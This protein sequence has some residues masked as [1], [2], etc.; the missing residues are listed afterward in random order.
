MKEECVFCEIYESGK[1]R[2]FENEDFF[3][4]FDLFPVSPGHVEIV[5]KRHV[6]SL[7]DLTAEEWM[8]LQ[9]ALAKAVE[10]I[11]ATDLQELYTLFLKE[12]ISEKAVQYYEAALKHPGLG[13][14][15]DGY[16]IGNNEGE[17]AGRTIHH[18]HIHIIPRY[19]GD[20]PDS[21]GGIRNIIPERGNY[22]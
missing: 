17:A 9:T 21:I 18:L 1:E 22:K 5:P 14:K 2:I 3:V 8:N 16:N 12:P 15:P 11:E 6:V 13:R 20:V 19:F 7:F 10:R 4:R